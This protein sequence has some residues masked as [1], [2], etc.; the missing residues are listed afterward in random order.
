[1]NCALNYLGGSQI[2][3]WFCSPPKSRRKSGFPAE[4]HPFWTT[5]CLYW[6]FV[7]IVVS[8]LI[9][10]VLILQHFRTL[11]S[12]LLKQMLWS[13]RSGNLAHS[14]HHFIFTSSSLPF[15]IGLFK[16]RG[17]F[18][19]FSSIKARH[20]VCYYWCKCLSLLFFS[21]LDFWLILISRNCLFF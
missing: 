19:F 20:T 21:P 1:M 3:M 4:S 16:S 2:C 15:K 5:G 18:F 13:H 8:N 12:D 9:Q 11:E 14:T 7:L 10:S 17:L 6:S